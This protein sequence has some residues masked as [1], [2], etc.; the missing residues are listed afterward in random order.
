M[1]RYTMM[2][3]AAALGV[4]SLMPAVAWA[5]ADDGGALKAALKNVAKYEFGQSREPLTVVAD[6]IRDSQNDPQVRAKLEDAMVVLLRSK[7]TRDAKDFACRQLA[8][9]GTDKTVPALAAMLGPSDT[10]DMARYALERIPGAAADKALIAAL[11]RTS[12]VVKVGVIN[13]LGAREC[14]AALGK[15]GPLAKGGDVAIAEAAIAALGKIGSADAAAALVA[16]RGRVADEVYPAWVDAYLLCADRARKAGDAAGAADRYAELLED[17]L[18]RVRVAAFMGLAAAAPERGLPLAIDALKG[19]CPDMLGAA[20]L[21]VRTMPGANATNAFVGLM[22]D[23]PAPTKALLLAA[24]ADRGDAAALAAVTDAA[25]S[26]DEAVRTAAM[27]AL[28]KLGS[29]GSVTILAKAAAEGGRTVAGAARTSLDTLRGNDVDA[30]L[31]A[32]LTESGDAGV[33]AELARALAA[34]NAATAV[35]ALQ[36]TAQ[37]S[38]EKVRAE[39]FKA[40]GALAK[41]ADLPGLVKLLIKVDGSRA[42]KEAE[43]AVVAVSKQIPETD[44]RG[45]AALAGLKKARRAEAKA[46]LYAVLGQIGDPNGLKPLRKA[47]KRGKPETQAAAVRALAGWPT[48][49]AVDDLVVIAGRGKNETHTALALRGLLRLLEIQGRE[50]VDEKMAYY[51]KAMKAAST[52]DQKK[53]VIGALANVHDFGALKLIEPYLDDPELKEEAVLAA[54]KVRTSF[55]KATASAGAGDAAKAIDG[56]ADSRWATGSPQKGGEWFQVDLGGEYSVKGVVLDTAK[57]ADDYPRAYQVFVSND[58]DNWGN[59]VAEGQGVKGVTKI[60]FDALSGRYVKIV[61]TGA[62]ESNWWGIHEL[63]IEAR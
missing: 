63:S 19:D 23:L 62:D 25:G 5:Q 10:S 24:L 7:S 3:M 30:A 8:L 15:L 28:G 12:G 48:V 39:S 9:I 59:A 11:G 49:A 51:E 1:R 47:A 34:R 13:S 41:A 31:V 43:R 29:A 35:P 55:Y 37:D 46:S 54:N 45:A 20:L 17:E 52:T 16:A 14:A 44:Q 40:L 4:V 26:E 22:P 58:T 2:L 61:Q 6:A 38:D 42:R 60:S 27:A 53:M 21:C 18:A 36:K 32:L 56:N 33:K 57:S 50:G